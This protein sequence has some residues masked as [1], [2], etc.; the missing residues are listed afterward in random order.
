VT[1]PY[2]VRARIRRAWRAAHLVFA[3]LTLVLAA[4]AA[5]AQAVTPAD[6]ARHATAADLAVLDLAQL[7]KIE[8]VVAAS[9]REQRT[10]DVPSFVSVVT[11]AQIRDHGY[12]T[13]ADVLRTLPSFQ[14]LIHI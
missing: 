8:V 12:R 7:M 11:A 4:R 10:R 1:A 5:S 9:K 2:H 13:L 6:S 14:T 3:G